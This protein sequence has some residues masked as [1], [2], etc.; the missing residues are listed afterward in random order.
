[1]FGGNTVKKILL[2]YPQD[3]RISTFLLD[4]F[5]N[6]LNIARNTEEYEL[7]IV[8]PWITDSLLD[9]SAKG[10]FGN[11]WPGFSKSSIPLK[12]ILQ[13]FL[14]YDRKILAHLVV[15]RAP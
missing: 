4:F 3:E 6:E 13:K 9:L 1:M 8:S 15:G 2:N 11:V 7:W 5:W 14:E 12:S 10:E